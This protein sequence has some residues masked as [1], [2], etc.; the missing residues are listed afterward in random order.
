MLVW[1]VS[2]LLGWFVEPAMT[3]N[4]E[5]TNIK[6]G[7]G[8][9]WIAIYKPEEKFASKEKPKIYRIV[10]VKGAAPQL[11]A[12]D[13]APGRYALA[14]YHDLNSNGV[15]D[16]NFVGIPKEPYGFSKNFR[17]KFSAPKFEDCEFVFK[18][19]GQKINV[20]LTD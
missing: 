12:F 1:I 2:C 16:K 6:K 10:D 13:L 20:K 11:V 5:F 14:V 18:D 19:P 3:L 4:I 9:L 7:Q 15:L 8:K 17:P